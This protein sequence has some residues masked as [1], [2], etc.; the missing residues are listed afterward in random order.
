MRRVVVCVGANY[1][2]MIE[3]SDEGVCGVWVWRMLGGSV[4]WFKLREQIYTIPGD[5]VLDVRVRRV[6][7]YV[8]AKSRCVGGCKG[9]C[10]CGCEGWLCVGAKGGCVCVWVRRVVVYV[11]AKGGCVCGCVARLCVWV[12]RVV[13]YVGATGSCVCGCKGWL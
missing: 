9:G 6:V 1:A 10:V 8:G 12:Q 5:W 7:V 2:W 3:F 11:G 4:C 13:M